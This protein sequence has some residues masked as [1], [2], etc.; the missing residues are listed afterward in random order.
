[1]RMISPVFFEFPCSSLLLRSRHYGETAVGEEERRALPVT[2]PSRLLQDC[3]RHILV[4][5]AISAE[6]KQL[7]RRSDGA[8]DTSI[9]K[10]TIANNLSLLLYAVSAERLSG[11]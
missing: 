10:K 7:Q 2:F 9:R 11:S 4:S 3:Y 1:M 6:G 5:L 8:L